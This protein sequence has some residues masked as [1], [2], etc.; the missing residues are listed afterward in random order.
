MFIN[1]LKSAIRNLK[2]TKLFSLVNILGLAVGMTACL[3]I[4]HYVTFEKS[5]DKFYE[6]S[7]RIYRLRYERTSQE[8]KAVKFASCCPP[9]GAAIRGKYPEVEKI[10]RIYQVDA[11]VS[12]KDRDIKF[13]EK[14]IYY[15]EPEFFDILKLT[16]SEGDP[17]QGIREPNK[18]FISRSTAR[19]YFGQQNPMGKTF[20][21]DNKEDYKIVG[22]FEDLPQNSHVKIDILLSFKNLETLFKEVMQSWGHTGFYTYLRL[23]PGADPMAFEKKLVDLVE[24]SCGDLMKHYK[25]LI[26]LKMQPMTDIH[27]TSHFMQE[28]EINSDIDSV[29][30][31]FI[32][33][34]FI[35]IM[36]WVNYIN[37]STTRSLT[38][39]REVG[40]RKVVGA[41]RHQLMIQFFFETILINLV[42]ILLAFVLLKLFLPFFIQITGTP[43]DYSFWTEGW[44]WTAVPIMFIVGVFLS[45]LYPVAAMSSFKPTN[46]LRGKLGNSAKGINLRKALVIFQFLIALALITGTFSVYR[47]ITYMKSQELGFDMEDILVVEAPR[48][49]DKTFGEKLITFKEELQKNANIKKLCVVSEVPGRQ[50]LWDNGGIRRRGEDTSKGKN[51][52]I[53]GIDWDFVDVFDLKILHGRNFSRKF[54]ADKDA[55]ILN[56][57]AV[58][59]MGF[60][61]SAEAIGQQVDYWGE[62]FTIIGVMKDY[63]QESLKA[64][65]E[66]HIL[67]LMPHG[68]GLSG[69]FAL[70]INPQ[71][72]RDTIRLVQQR[73][74]EF[75]PGNPFDYFFLED[76]YNQQYTDDERFGKVVGIFS[77]LAIFVTILGIFGLSSFMAVQRTRE[78]GIRKI[79]GATVPNILQLLTK[80]FLVLI[81]ISFLIALPLSFFGIR[82]WLNSFAYRMDLH[83]WLF[84]FPLFIVTGLTL[85]TIS[86]HVIRVAL[87]NP[88]DSIKYE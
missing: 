54:P 33:A 60:N 49:R 70:K 63:H 24:A 55:L 64:A 75:F 27:L 4:L 14:K 87:T 57:T 11:I 66:P 58:K 50:I 23:K 44:F 19:K 67:R 77:F 82:E 74:E 35:I 16:F 25:V 71:H 69:N 9:A 31:L 48:I 22:I 51:Y 3:L 40:L 20:S 7:E 79:L 65:F 8:G 13:K 36:A 56:E 39:A 15:A 41:S 62:F 88:V 34:L 61:S 28:Y 84:V 72:V 6:G 5:Y 68:W 2:K 85:F 81:F 30:F 12:L 83:G 46:V 78:I 42:A 37:L 17:L 29:N 47:Q 43:P 18:A 59:W 26:E 38:R 76:Y 45:G 10:A 1:Y 73:F 80:D 53:V 32:I 21:V 86:S 52:Q